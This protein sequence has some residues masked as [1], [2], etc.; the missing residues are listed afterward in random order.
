MYVSWV[1]EPKGDAAVGRDGARSVFLSLPPDA[2]VLRKAFREAGAHV[3]IDTDDVVAA[4]RGYLMV[5]AASDGEKRIRLPR[6]C[7][8][9]EIFGAS[10]P[11]TGVCEI[12]EGM[13]L[14]ETRVFRISAGVN[15]REWQSW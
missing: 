10:R 12:V 13:K 2:A 5:H 3:W 1:L 9:R 7:D 4:G 11:R 14:G 6:K 15:S 8:V